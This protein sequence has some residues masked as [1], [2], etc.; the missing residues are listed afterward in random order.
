MNTNSIPLDEMNR[1][2]T[3]GNCYFI[4]LEFIKD[5]DELA[6]KGAFGNSPVIQLVHGLVRQVPGDSLSQTIRHAWIEVNHEHVIDASN[7]GIEKMS[8]FDYHRMRGS[9]VK[10]RFSRTEA[11]AIISSGPDGLYW[12]DYSDEQVS[13]CM[14]NYSSA[15]SAF[16]NGLVFS[17]QIATRLPH[18]QS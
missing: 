15:S 3:K 9:Q 2:W 5:S 7:G 1:D 4:A 8:V 18:A 11:D 16:S 10:R 14:T 13:I 17:L 6:A 12:G